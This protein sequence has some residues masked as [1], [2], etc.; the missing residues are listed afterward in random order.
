M[1]VDEERVG[2]KRKRSLSDDDESMEIDGETGTKEASSQ[3][4]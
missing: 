3:K 2:R 4:K 1:E